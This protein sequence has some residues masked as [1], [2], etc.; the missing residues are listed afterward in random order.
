MIFQM[1]LKYLV[2]RVLVLVFENSSLKTFFKNTGAYHFGVLLKM[3]L[4]Y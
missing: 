1:D 4:F 2:K 3:L